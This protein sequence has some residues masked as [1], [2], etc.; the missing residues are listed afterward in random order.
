MALGGKQNIKAVDACITRLRLTLDDSSIVDDDE[1]KKLGASGV[2][3]PNSK[4]M[5]V[6]VGPKAELVVDEIKKVL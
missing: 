5:Q 1:L 2:L 4:N 6:V 3:R